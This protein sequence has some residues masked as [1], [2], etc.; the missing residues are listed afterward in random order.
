MGKEYKLVVYNGVVKI[1]DPDGFYIDLITF[2]RRRFPQLTFKERVDWFAPNDLASSW[3]DVYYKGMRMRKEYDRKPNNLHGV[4]ALSN[5]DKKFMD[6]YNDIEEARFGLKKL[7]D[8]IQNWY[9]NIY[10]ETKID[11]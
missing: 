3:C 1:K 2:L 9:D 8:R 7:C 4:P 5:R 10:K 6:W 11:F